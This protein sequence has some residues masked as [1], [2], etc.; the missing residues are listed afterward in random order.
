MGEPKAQKIGP[1]FK[2][3]QK[4]APLSSSKIGSSFKPIQKLVPVS[5]L[6]E[7]CSQ[8]QANQKLVP[9]S[10]HHRK[11][12]PL[13]SSKI[14][15]S[16]KPNQK[17]VPVSRPFKNWFHFQAQLKFGP[18]FK[19]NFG[20]LDSKSHENW[21]KKKSPKKLSFLKAIFQKLVEKLLEK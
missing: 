5:S 21:F 7:N 8:F 3:S 17:L 9:V 20:W 19:L 6:V 10:N 2:P 16:F 4:L 12:V 14:G 1:S 15:S 18:A 11:L 13:S